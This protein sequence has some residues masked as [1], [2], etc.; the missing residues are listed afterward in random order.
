ME[1]VYAN[2][3]GVGMVELTHGIPSGAPGE[4]IPYR[5]IKRAGIIARILGR[6]R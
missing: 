6:F 2:I 1:K 5:P 4:V 3:R